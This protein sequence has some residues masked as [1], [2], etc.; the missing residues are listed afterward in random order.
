MPTGISVLFGVTVLTT[1]FLFYR[2]TGHSKRMLA[3]IAGWSLLQ[4]L[5]A[6]NGFFL[7]TG[8]MPPRFI[9]AILPPV[10]VTIFMFSASK[11]QAWLEQMDSASLTLL[12]VV[13]IPVELT[14]FLLFTHRLMPKLMTFEGQ[15]LDII[16]GVTAPVVWY[17][18]YVKGRLGRNILIA[19]NLICLGILAVTVTTGILSVPTP[20]QQIGFDQPSR[21]ILYFPFVLL[22]ALI[23]PI[24]YF[25]HLVT[26][27]R[28][29]RTRSAP[30]DG[31]IAP[32]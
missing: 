7:D 12:H 18:G 21:A 22:P 19:W 16:S 14:L 24:V 30:A 32:R 13:R 1:V 11:G 10:V 28:L 2:A 8:A 6:Y 9:V 20:F 3:L 5:L 15:N 29:L 4:S 27:R 31:F 26:L 25:S 17:F 23:V